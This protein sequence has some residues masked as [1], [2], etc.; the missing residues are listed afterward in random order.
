MSSDP[1]EHLL[2]SFDKVYKPAGQDNELCRAYSKYE[3]LHSCQKTED[4]SQMFNTHGLLRKANRGNN[5]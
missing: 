5:F 1:G 2:G 4:D 3:S